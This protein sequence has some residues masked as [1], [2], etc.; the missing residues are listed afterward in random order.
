MTERLIRTH[1]IITEC[2][3]VKS[4]YELNGSPIES[5][6]VQHALVVLC[7][8]MQYEIYDIVENRAKQ[9]SDQQLTKFVSSAAHKVLRGVLSSEIVGFVGCFGEDEK[10]KFRNSIREEDFTKYNNA[11][12]NRH[13]VAHQNNAQLNVQVTFLELK[14]AYSIATDILAAMESSIN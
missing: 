1:T 8:E 11:V 9:A 12:S 14:E 6:L 2:E 10:D 7:A 5:Y 3:A 4:I 13:K